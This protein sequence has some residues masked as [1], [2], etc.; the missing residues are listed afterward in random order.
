MEIRS[1]FMSGTKHKR[2]YNKEFKKELGSTTPSPPINYTSSF[3]MSIS[4]MNCAK[5]MGSSLNTFQ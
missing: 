1:V 3:Y 5:Q 4:K 2:T